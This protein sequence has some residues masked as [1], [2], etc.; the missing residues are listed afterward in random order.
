[1]SAANLFLVLHFVGLLLWIGGATALAWTAAAL[2]SAGETKALSAVRS[3]LLAIVAPG[4]LLATVG[5]LARLVPAW[6]A[7]YA[8]AP[9]MHVKITIGLVLG[10]LH[11]VL[12]NRVRK[13]ASGQPVPPGLFVGLAVANVAL[14]LGAVACAI[15][16][17]GQ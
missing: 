14:G 2:V 15:L 10:G 1:M 5:G 7:L 3:G 6:G 11:G 4:I 16:R 13:A 12:V 17:F 9:W 8:H